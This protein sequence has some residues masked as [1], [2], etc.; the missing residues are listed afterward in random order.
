[1]KALVRRGRGN[2]S[3]HVTRL[4]AISALV[5]AAK[6]RNP[7]PSGTLVVGVGLL[8]AGVSAYAFLALSQRMLGEHGRAPLGAQWS[9]VFL[10]GPGLFLP[11]EQEV[12][13]AL[14]DRRARGVG[15]A[16]VVRRAATIGVGLVLGVLI[17]L[18]A[19]ARWVVDELFDHQLLLLVGLALGLVAALAG[20]LT[21]GCLSGTGH[22]KGYGT[23]MAADGVIRFLGCV[24]IAVLGARMAGWYGVAVGI[25]GLLAVPVALR[26][27]RPQLQPGPESAWAEISSALGWL[28]AASLFAFTLMNIGPVA[29]QALATD[30]QSEIAGRFLS[31][32]VVARV[33]LY[34]FQAIQAALL[35]KLTSLAS[36]GRLGDF[37]RGLRRLLV[38]VAGLAVV[39]TLVGSVMG[40]LVVKIMSGP[41][42]VVGHRTMALLAA[43][44]GFY[45]LA[46]ALAQAVI[47]L[48][49][50]REQ[51]I[52]WA[53]G[54][55]AFA[56]TTLLVS[57]DLFLRV[58][59]GL[60]V[61]SLVAFVVMAGLVAW[62]LA[63]VT[64]M[65]GRLEIESGDF[66]EALHD[67]AVEP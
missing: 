16:P 14:A 62:R 8:I 5:D 32:V 28:L 51:A 66:I 18:I 43:G 6:R 20:H 46:L 60:L 21:R 56:P 57:D 2:D 15:S 36:V 13:R 58:E 39:G 10:L 37:R 33:P 9:L 17:L 38:M 61:G 52:G 48:G 35:P 41:D 67:V 25:A 47:A 29:V 24:I 3:R 4:S 53:A 44:S 30:G 63:L 54:V 50:H 34:L 19:S 55:L 27:E 7:L 64:Q 11:L 59:L 1:M 23:Y 65:K 31:A 22:F 45:M 49:G 42:V 26:V 40:P 12:S